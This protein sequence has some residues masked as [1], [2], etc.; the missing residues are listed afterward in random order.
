MRFVKFLLLLVIVCFCCLQAIFLLFRKG[1][2]TY[3]AFEQKRLKEIINGT[4]YYDAVFLGS[5]RTYYHI[6]PRIIDSA[7][8]IRSFN[9]GIDGANILE[10]NMIL[11]C[12][13]AKHPTPKY[14][15]VD[16]STSGFDVVELPMWNPNVYYPFLDNEIVF[17]TLKSFKRAYLL[18]YLPF[19]QMTECDD[20]LRQGAFAGVVGKRRPLAP[21]YDN[22][23]IESGTDT[24]PLPFKVF[25]L[26]T[27]FPVPQEGISQLED[28]IKTCNNHRIKL[29]ITYAPVYKF[30]DEKLNASFFPTLKYVCDSSNTPFLNYRY[31]SINNDH[32][33][34]R[35]EHHLNTY[36][37]DIYSGL[38]ARD[39]KEMEAR[40]NKF[41]NDHVNF[42]QD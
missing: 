3:Y 30:H 38:V 4:D 41:R 31:E 35:D 13:L 33:L 20:I 11:K 14:V 42:K 16:V 32:R 23:Y 29:F 17:R 19:L 1:Y 24:I 27:D 36:G 37:A 25:Y 15:I 2:N 7:L 28:L 40:N 39:I 9:A 12:Y 34:F 10:C 26:K 6:N 22:G 8:Q 5:S 21:H 18:K